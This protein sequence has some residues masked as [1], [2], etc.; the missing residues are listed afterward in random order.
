VDELQTGCASATK[1]VIE[2]RRSDHEETTTGAGVSDKN[3]ETRDI[4]VTSS[5]RKLKA[6]AKAR[7]SYTARVTVKPDQPRFTIIGSGS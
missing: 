2:I 5:C 3:V 4:D 7:D 6:K 1:V